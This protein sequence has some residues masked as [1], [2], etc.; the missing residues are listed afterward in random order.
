VE[1][2]IPQLEMEVVEATNG[3]PPLT[4]EK[5]K[6]HDTCVLNLPSY[7]VDSAE[8]IFQR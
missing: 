5:V 4:Q 7:E 6:E 3:D 1:V 8:H 2:D